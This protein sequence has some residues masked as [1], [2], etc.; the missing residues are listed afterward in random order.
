MLS[1]YD[2]RNESELRDWESRI[3]RR[4][5]LAPN[6][7]L[8]YVCEPKFDGLAIS[9][10]YE[11]GKLVRGLTRGDGSKGEDIT[12]NLKTVASI[13]LQ[14]K[15]Q[16]TPPLLEVRGEL[17]MARPD[18]EKLNVAQKQNAAPL[19]ANPRNAAAGSARQKDPRVT[20]SRPLRFTA[21]APGKMDGLPIQTQT[22]W[23]QWLRDAGFRVDTNWKTARGL[24]EVL[25]FINEWRTK[26]REVDFPTDGVVVKINSFAMQSELGFV[27]RD[28][29]WAVA[30]KYAPDEVTTKVLDI[31]V[32]VG[33]TGVLTPVALLEPIEIAGSLVS[34]A[35]L[36]NEDEVRRLDIRVGDKVLVHKANEIIPEVVRVLASQRTGT[37]QPFV[38]PTTCPACG[39]PVVRLPGEVASRCENASCPAQLGR[40]VEHFAARDA[41]NISGLGP[42]L[43]KQLLDAKLINDVADL[44]ALQKSDLMKLP[45]MGE[46]SAARVLVSIENSKHPTFARLIYAVGIPDVGQKTAQVLAARFD[47]WQV[48]T[49]AREAEVAQVPG[50]G[51]VAARSLKS[52]LSDKRNQTLLQ[53]LESAGVVATSTR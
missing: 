35:S 26:R 18:F 20:A 23:L 13:P 12:A 28:P 19:F 7:V 3:H 25:A 15:L 27:G 4:L 43:I 48:L 24:D 47:S 14:L 36:H 38:F 37:E 2:V 10:S 41:M 34:K 51:A 9:L 49:A 6:K 53:N 40:L 33:R 50:V 1:L 44:Y 29:R 42:K 5:N 32:T 21:Y 17:Y 52:W 30:F 31:Q 11:N 22:Q 46:K 16:S 39:A 8:E 45:R